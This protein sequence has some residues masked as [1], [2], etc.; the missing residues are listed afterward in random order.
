[1]TNIL[2][3]GALDSDEQI[4]ENCKSLG[5]LLIKKLRIAGH[6]TVLVGC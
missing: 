6:N 4:C 3:G 2:Y 5:E 1:M